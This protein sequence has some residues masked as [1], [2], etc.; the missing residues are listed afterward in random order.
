[1]F[2]LSLQFTISGDM[3]LLHVVRRV[4]YWPST[5]SQSR[6]SCCVCYAGWL[7]EQC[8][9]APVQLVHS[10]PQMYR[11]LHYLGSSLYIIPH[12]PVA[13]RARGSQERSVALRGKQGFLRDVVPYCC[14]TEAIMF[15]WCHYYKH[16][17]ICKR[18]PFKYHTNTIFH[19]ILTWYSKDFWLPVNLG[20]KSLL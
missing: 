19:K 15:T 13:S 1:M 3:S 11:V 2:T 5:F 12:V 8:S 16:L 20:W 17:W 6:W 14:A 7:T 9:N 10:H 4:R 18:N